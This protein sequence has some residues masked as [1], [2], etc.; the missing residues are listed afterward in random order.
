MARVVSRCTE[1][2][3]FLLLQIEAEQPIDYPVEARKQIERHAWRSGT[4]RVSD[5]VRR[6][7]RVRS[8]GPDSSSANTAPETA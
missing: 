1:R 7:Q 3:N 4:N 2:A 8:H 5:R 6:Q